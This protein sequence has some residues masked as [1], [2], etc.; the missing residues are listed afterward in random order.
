MIT[1]IGLLQGYEQA[2]MRSKGSCAVKTAFF[3]LLSKAN[4]KVYLIL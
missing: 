1:N 3:Q 2:A 4:F